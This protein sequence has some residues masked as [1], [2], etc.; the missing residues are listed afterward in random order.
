M[1]VA[2][3]PSLQMSLHL[4]E[5]AIGPLGIFWHT[6]RHLWTVHTGPSTTDSWAL[7]TDRTAAYTHQP[8]A[9]TGAHI[10]HSQVHPS[11]SLIIANFQLNTTRTI[12][13][14]AISFRWPTSLA[15]ICLTTPKR[16]SLL[17][18]AHSP[19]VCGYDWCSP[20]EWITLD[21]TFV[22]HQYTLSLW[23]LVAP[24]TW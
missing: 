6:L 13:S 9:D 12:T 2:L 16:R 10:V 15:F 5:L 14:S 20:G 4:L 8:S 3:W 18:F 1:R 7:Q 24:T 23:A 17:A 22:N 19:T 11:S 21:N